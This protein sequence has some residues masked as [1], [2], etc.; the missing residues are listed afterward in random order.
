MNV[1]TIARLAQIT[2]SAA[3]A[4]YLLVGHSRVTL[5]TILVAYALP[6]VAQLATYWVI[7]AEREAVGYG[8]EP[9]WRQKTASFI[10]A[11]VS[12]GELPITTTLIL[13]IGADAFLEVSIGGLSRSPH[14]GSAEPWV[15]LGFTAASLAVLAYRRR[16]LRVERSL[17]EQVRRA[18]GFE[19]LA[20]LALAVRDLANTPIQVLVFNVEV[21]AQRHPESQ[22]HFER[23]RRALRKL[24]DLNR[25]LEPYES[26]VR[27]RPDLESPDS[28]SLLRQ[29]STPEH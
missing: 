28:E 19:Q 2:L 26:G 22:L 6:F 15:T 11:V 24:R 25:L 20:H 29:L 10:L 8:W 18:Q 12:P 27:W 9:L 16:R 13:A 14:L 17:V 1:L 7:T 23:I 4:V 21:L 3:L 5:R